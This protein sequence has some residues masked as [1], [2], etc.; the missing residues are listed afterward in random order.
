MTTF[1]L[2]HGGW[3]GGWSWR[4]VAPLLQAEDNE[5]HA[6]TLTGL[7]DRSHLARPDTGL[8]VHVEDVIAVLELDDLRDVVLVGHSYSGVVITGVAQRSGER[9]GELVYL[10]AFVPQPGQSLFA[11]MPPERRDFYLSA[12]DKAGGIMPD[13]ETAMDGW[14]VTDPADR[15]W[16]RPRLRAQ[17][18]HTMSD[19]LPPHRLPDLS[20]TYIHCTIKPGPDRFTGF[21]A[22]AREDPSWRFDEL[23]A[24]HDAMVTA[25]AELAALLRR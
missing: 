13:P 4:R 6:P 22:T 11:L 10:D 15:A 24:G 18:F 3:H 20:R 25:P 19:P 9:I 2:V 12:T 8:A 1:V 17:P 16:V 5:V 21:A 14:A 7:G 23:A